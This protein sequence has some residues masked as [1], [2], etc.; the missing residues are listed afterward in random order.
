MVFR[1]C[2]CCLN[3]CL[4]CM[5]SCLQFLSK[6]A[7]IMVGVQGKGFCKSA[8]E[9]W[10][11]MARNPRRFVIFQGVMWTVDVACRFL[12]I[13]LTLAFGGLFLDRKVSP[14]VKS[15]WAPLIMIALIGYFI[16]G[17]IA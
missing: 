8:W 7:Y 10:T 1:I 6:N 5:V 14:D 12:L 15:P 3:C 16:S 17:L 11:V 2:C 9:V 4:R 13:G